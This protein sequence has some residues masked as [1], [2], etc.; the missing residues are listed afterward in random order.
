MRLDAD[1]FGRRFLL[2]VLPRGFTWLRHYWL[3]ANRC[4]ARKLALCRG[5]LHQPAPEPR[6]PETTGEILLRLTGIDMTACVQCGE[7]TLGACAAERSARQ[8]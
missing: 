7:G 6:E 4:R 3:L 2:H 1:E 8:S 5:L